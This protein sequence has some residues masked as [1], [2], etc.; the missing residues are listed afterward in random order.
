MPCSRT[1]ERK[2]G[3]RGLG[4]RSASFLG[5]GSGKDW[6]ALSARRPSP[7]CQKMSAKLYAIAEWAVLVPTKRTK[8]FAGASKPAGRSTSNARMPDTMGLTK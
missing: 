4:S 7:E 2:K 6:K 1:R 8:R 5:W 3:A